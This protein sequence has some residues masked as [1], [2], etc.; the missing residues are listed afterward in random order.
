MTDLQFLKLLRMVLMI[1]DGCKDLDDAK[2]KIREL[3]EEHKNTGQ[4]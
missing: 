2:S 1:L 3:I 4:E